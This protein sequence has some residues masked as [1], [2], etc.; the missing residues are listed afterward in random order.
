MT[1]EELVKLYQEG[2]K[3]ALEMLLEVNKGFIYKVSVKMYTGKDNAIDHD[4]LLQECR[5]G[6]IKAADKYKS[7][8]AANFLTYAYYWM[9]QFMYRFMYPKRNMV[10]SRLKF[11]SL[12][13][14]I[15]ES[16]DIELGDTLGEED[17]EF[18]SVEDSIYHQELNRE[19]RQAMNDNLN[20]KEMNV[21]YLRYGFD[22]D[23]CTLEQTGEKLGFSRARAWELERQSLRRLRSSRWG[24]MKRLENRQEYHFN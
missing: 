12:N 18:C 20:E 11:I 23:I 3:Q 24:R 2:D 16:E 10:N 15:G 13:V 4:D 22:S 17:E 6:M 5:I 1:N 7:D 8:M 14:Q 19:L 9:Y 21:I